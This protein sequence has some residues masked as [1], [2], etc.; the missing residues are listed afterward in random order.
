MKELIKIPQKQKKVK[1]KIKTEEGSK[2]A[3]KRRYIQEES[4]WKCLICNVLFPKKNQ[5]RHHSDTCFES[6]D[7]G[8]KCGGCKELYQGIAEL[9]EH[10]SARIDCYNGAVPTLICDSCPKPHIFYN[11]MCGYNEV[12]PKCI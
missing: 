2:R 6:F 5:I 12:Q 11:K 3:R 10:L 9:K 1:I 4:G 8:Y 7:D